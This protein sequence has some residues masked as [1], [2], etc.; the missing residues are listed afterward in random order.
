MSQHHNTILRRRVY[1]GPFQYI[2][3]PQNKIPYDKL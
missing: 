2:L 3:R 1:A